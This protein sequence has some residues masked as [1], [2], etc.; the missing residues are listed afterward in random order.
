VPDLGAF[1]RTITVSWCMTVSATCLAVPFRYV[2]LLFL[3]CFDV[4][5]GVQYQHIVMTMKLQWNLW[6]V[7]NIFYN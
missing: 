2:F 5:K 3:V 4:Y 7:R 6:L 1:E